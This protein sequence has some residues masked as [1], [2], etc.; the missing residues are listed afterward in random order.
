LSYL[1]KN[2]LRIIPSIQF[3]VD[4]SLDYIDG[5]ENAIKKGENPIK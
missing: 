5:I 1:V 2:Q 3:F 4:D